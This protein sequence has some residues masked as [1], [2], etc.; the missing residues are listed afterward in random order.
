MLVFIVLSWTHALFLCLCSFLLQMSNF[1][2]KI[3]HC[4]GDFFSH[5]AIKYIMAPSYLQDKVKLP[6][7]YSRTF[8]SGPHVILSLLLPYFLYIHQCPSLNRPSSLSKRQY[9]SMSLCLLPKPF[10]L[11]CPS[12]P[13]LS[14]NTIH[15]SKPSQI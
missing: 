3:I 14:G 1:L 11:E 13:W 5:S 12:I 10:L 8:N 15:S 2:R 9:T 7:R 6:A 4:K